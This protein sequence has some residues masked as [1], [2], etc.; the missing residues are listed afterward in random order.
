MSSL[1]RPHIG[2]L[3]RRVAPL[4]LLPSLTLVGGCVVSVPPIQPAPDDGPDAVDR[5][6][7]LARRIVASRKRL[8]EDIPRAVKKLQWGLLARP[9]VND[10]GVVRSEVLLT[11]S[12]TVRIEATPLESPDAAAQTAAKRRDSSAAIEPK[13][14]PDAAPPVGLTVGAEDEPPGPE[15]ASPQTQDRAQPYLVRVFVPPYGDSAISR[16]FLDVLE[17]TLQGPPRREY[18][19]SFELPER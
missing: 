14:D 11:D 6:P 15:A 4:I 19:G 16:K 12:R 17:T 13:A 9:V 5:Q 2:P 7:V 3:L 10:E 1:R 18:R 8:T